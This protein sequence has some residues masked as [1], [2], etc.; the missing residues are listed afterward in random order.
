MLQIVADENIPLVEEVFSPLG[1]V[2]RVNGRA[3]SRQQLAQADILLVRSVTQVNQ[4]LL[5]GTPVRFVATAT[6]GTDHLDTDYLDAAGIAWANAPGSNASSV[7]EYVISALCRLN[8][9][10][11]QL[12][13]GASVGIIGMGNV[14]SR[15]YQRLTA[16]GIRCRGYD[17]LIPQDRYPV[18]SSLQAVLASDVLCLHTP[19][20]CS[21]PHPSHHLLNS[22][23]LK[24]LNPAA[25]LINAGRG[26]AIDN[27]ALLD[28][29]PTWQG[30]TVLDVWEAEPTISMPL[31]AQVDI[32]TPHIAGYSYDGKVAGTAMIY[33][34]CCA[35]LGLNQGD[36]GSKVESAGDLVVSHVDNP[37]AA[38]KEAVLA[39]YDLMEDDRRL[40]SSLERAEDAGEAFDRLRKEYPRRR[41]FKA[42]RIANGDGLSPAVRQLLSGLGF[43]C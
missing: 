17:P 15:L 39:S 3:L 13:E 31:M 7:V 2:R 41:E 36:A 21:G 40:R 14:G 35:F 5:E 38:V 19:W 43:Q 26:P 37:V 22:K 30:R 23:R 4:A 42:Y 32:A 11:E 34:A 29:L 12:L 6:I 8:G 18:L 16:L 27:Q 10:L 33:A 24:Q 20:T 1:A 9:A 25:V 28:F